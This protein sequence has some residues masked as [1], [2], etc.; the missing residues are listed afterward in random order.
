LR[1]PHSATWHRKTFAVHLLPDPTQDQGER[2]ALVDGLVSGPFGIY[3]G[4]PYRIEPGRFTLVHLPSPSTTVGSNPTR[5]KLTSTAEACWKRLQA[6]PPDHRVFLLRSVRAFQT[7]AF[8]V[9][10]CAESRAAAPKDASRAL[11]LANLALY[12]AQHVPGDI[13]PRCQAYAWAFVA[14][15]HR[16]SGKLPK[17]NTAFARALDLWAAGKVGDPFLS[18]ARFLDLEASLRRDQRRIDE[19]LDLLARAFA[20]AKPEEKGSLLI[21]GGEALRREREGCGG[22][23]CR[24]GAGA[25]RGPARGCAIRRGGGGLRLGGEPLPPTHPTGKIRPTSE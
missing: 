1:L 18:E 6:A 16:V 3:S 9:R 24:E 4:S 21:K 12:V 14:N 11:T 10:V 15:A 8:C 23:G 20:L 22:G 19:A 2:A 7:T 17:A 13:N 5:V 25:G